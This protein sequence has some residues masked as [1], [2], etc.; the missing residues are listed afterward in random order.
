MPLKRGYSDKT[1][2]ENI[3]KLLEEGYKKEQALAIA[4][5]EAEKAKKKRKK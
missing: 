2:Q 4:L 1:V 3:R 5:A